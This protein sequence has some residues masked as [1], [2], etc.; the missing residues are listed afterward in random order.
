MRKSGMKVASKEMSCNVELC[1][2]PFSLHYF[3]PPSFKKYNIDIV[4]EIKLITRTL[5]TIYTEDSKSNPYF[6]STTDYVKKKTQEILEL[7]KRSGYRVLVLNSYFNS[8]GIFVF[9]KKFSM[10]DNCF[11]GKSD[12]FYS[13]AFTEIRKLAMKCEWEMMNKRGKKNEENIHCY[14]KC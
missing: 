5:C 4:S 9:G 7:S 2:I 14:G 10:V 12:G 6:N 11:G 3:K 13:I 8:I 1:G